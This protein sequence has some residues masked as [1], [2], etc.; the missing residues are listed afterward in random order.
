M[1]H[2]RIKQTNATILNGKVNEAT[3]ASTIY[4]GVVYFV[5]ATIATIY[6]DVIRWKHF[7]VTG[8]LW[9]ESTSSHAKP[10]T[11]SN[12]IYKYIYVLS[13]AKTQKYIMI[14]ESWRLTLYIT[15]PHIPVSQA[16]LNRP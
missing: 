11:D 10:S 5:Y 3:T 12:I 16:V 1:S 9:G 7:R 4:V 14:Y 15:W 13:N 2:A 6:Y 8:P